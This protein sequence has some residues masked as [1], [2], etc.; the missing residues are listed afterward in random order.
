MDRRSE[1][2]LYK[3]V[4]VGEMFSSKKVGGL[5]SESPAMTTSSRPDNGQFPM[6]NE[7]REGIV[8]R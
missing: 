5:G 1:L 3:S 8:A 4:Q 2:Y 7:D 6:E